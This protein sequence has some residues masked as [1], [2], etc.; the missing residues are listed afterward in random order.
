[1]LKELLKGVKVFDWIGGILYFL[2]YGFLFSILPA[3]IVGMVSKGRGYSLLRYGALTLLYC[4]IGFTLPYYL[5]DGD[6]LVVIGSVLLP[7]LVMIVWVRR[8]P[9]KYVTHQRE[10]S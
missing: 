9:L 5:L 7:F 2:A 4:T 6:L 3:L 8:L 1:M 10:T